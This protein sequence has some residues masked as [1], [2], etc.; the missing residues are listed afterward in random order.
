M[1]N[2]VVLDEGLSSAREYHDLR[3]TYSEDLV[4]VQSAHPHVVCRF[5]TGLIARYTDRR[6]FREDGRTLEL[7]GMEERLWEMS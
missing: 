2:V 7:G 6:I 5:E 4:F 3:P 1:K